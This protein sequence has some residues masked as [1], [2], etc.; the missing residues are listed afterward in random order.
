MA[1]LNGAGELTGSI[2]IREWGVMETPVFLTATPYVGA[3]YHAATQVLGRAPAA[4][5]ASTT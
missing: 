3:V 5:S 1:V 2:Q 4:R